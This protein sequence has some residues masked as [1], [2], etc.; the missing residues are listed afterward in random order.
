MLSQYIEVLFRLLGRV[1]ICPFDTYLIWGFAETSS[2]GEE[3]EKGRRKGMEGRKGM[4]RKKKRRRDRRKEEMRREDGRKGR[5]GKR[6]VIPKVSLSMNN[7]GRG[8]I[9]K[10]HGRKERGEG[11][12]MEEVRGDRRKREKERWEEE[13]K[14]TA[15][16]IG[17]KP[18]YIDSQYCQ[19]GQIS[20]GRWSN[21]AYRFR[22]EATVFTL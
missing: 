7:G 6:C 16:A 8:G 19:H 1:P 4:E 21:D 20:L 15:N 22:G 5:E 9:G 12:K 10:K 17:I 2:V 14:K 13:G 18:Q 11:E 3:G